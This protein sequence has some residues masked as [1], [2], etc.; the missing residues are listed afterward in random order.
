VAAAPAPAGRAGLGELEGGSA[1][2]GS[3]R[4]G[5]LILVVGIGFFLKYAFDNAGSGRRAASRAGLFGVVLL[6]VGDRVHRAA[7]RAPAQGLG[8]RRH[9]HL[10][11]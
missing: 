10:F 1:P 6:V 9:R 5:A 8:G 4:A 2:A 7:Y 3:N 11:T